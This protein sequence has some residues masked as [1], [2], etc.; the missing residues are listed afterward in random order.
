MS[1]DDLRIRLRLPGGEATTLAVGGDTPFRDFL[2]TVSVAAQ[3]PAPSLRL[4]RGFPPAEISC[5]ADMPISVV[6][7]HMDTVSVACSDLAAPPP[8]SNGSNRRKPKQVQRIPPGAAAPELGQSG[9][10]SASAA[11]GPVEENEEDAGGNSRAA[12]F[13]RQGSKSRK[14]SLG[15]GTSSKS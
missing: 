5:G 14:T 7:K 10:A 15:W 9:A 2:A 3:K 1:A 12:G 13:P 4:S 6:L 8:S 11:G